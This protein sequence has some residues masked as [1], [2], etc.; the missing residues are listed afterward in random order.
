[1]TSSGAIISEK[2][3]SQSDTQTS[4]KKVTNLSDP[5]LYKPGSTPY[6][7]YTGAEVTR[8]RQVKRSSGNKYYGKSTYGIHDPETGKLKTYSEQEIQE[9]AQKQSELQTPSKVNSPSPKQSATSFSQMVKTP[10]DSYSKPFSKLPVDIQRQIVQ[11]AK[12]IDKSEEVIK[13][14]VRDLERQGYYQTSQ[15]EIDKIQSG[16]TIVQNRNEQLLLERSAR[17]GFQVT[18]NSQGEYEIS[19]AKDTINKIEQLRKEGKYSEAN[20][21]VNE[22]NQRVARIESAITNY[23]NV[24]TSFTTDINKIKQRIDTSSKIELLQRIKQSK[25]GMAKWNEANKQFTKDVQRS[26]TFGGEMNLSS[27]ARNY[28]VGTKHFE[29]IVNKLPNQNYGPGEMN[30]KRVLR[31]TSSYLR[32]PVTQPLTLSIV[33][34]AGTILGFGSATLKTTFPKQLF[35]KTASTLTGIGKGLTFLGTSAG[36]GAVTIGELQ[37]ARGPETLGQMGAYATIGTLGAIPGIKAGTSL[38]KSIR[39]FYFNRDIS[40]FWQS[41]TNTDFRYQTDQKGITSV[42]KQGTIGSDKQMQLRPSDYDIYSRYQQPQISSK[43]MDYSQQ[44]I[45]YKPTQTQYT[46]SYAKTIDLSKQQT[47]YENL[48]VGSKTTTINFGKTNKPTITFNFG[49]KGQAQLISQFKYPDTMLRW[50]NI[51]GSK[52][53]LSIPT[54]TIAGSIPTS[55]TAGFSMA[56]ALSIGASI[57]GATTLLQFWPKTIGTTRLQTFTMQT[58]KATVRTSPVT[59]TEQDTF[60]STVS[61]IG[62]TR[63]G[64]IPPPSPPTQPIIPVTPIIPFTGLLFPNLKSEVSKRRKKAGFKLK[65]KLTGRPTLLQSTKGIKVAKK[66]LLSKFSGFEAIRGKPIKL[67]RLKGSRKSGTRL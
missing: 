33:A 39:Q 27:F 6:K 60:I 55:M 2:M 59:L 15:Q 67:K 26:S 13:Q 42:D 49:K 32:T 30:P 31:M 66:S 35:P 23:D 10:Y 38:G 46:T 14:Q 44:R 62:G 20:V 47:L 17:A 45:I 8:V 54:S 25:T 52:S 22:Y 16:L 1:M 21:L 50:E 28:D 48:G 63:G 57:A 51:W 64:T 19:D 43:G 29:N 34:G 58:P 4:K 7:V 24:R 18:Q 65:S 41:K 53:T 56:G 11:D 12:G 36:A 5:S 37:G 40:N 9:L 3:D 61:D